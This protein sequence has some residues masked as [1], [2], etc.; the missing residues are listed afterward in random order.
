MPRRF[1]IEWLWWV[2]ACL[3]VTGYAFLTNDPSIH[4]PAELLMM[5]VLIGTPVYFGVGVIRLTVHA[6]VV[7]LGGRNKPTA[8]QED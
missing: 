3:S 2:A 6:L 1:A 5:S 4:E 7:V 8:A